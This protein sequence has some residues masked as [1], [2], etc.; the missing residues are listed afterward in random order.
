MSEPAARPSDPYAN[1]STAASL[2]YTD[3]DA[4][5]AQAEAER[6][7]IQ[8][9]VGTWE[10]I[11]SPTPPLVAS[12]EEE[13][14]EDVKPETGQKR[15]AGAVPDDDDDVRRFRLKR[16]TIGAGLGEIYDPAG[17]EGGGKEENASGAILSEGVSAGEVGAD[18]VAPAGASQRPKW[19]AR[20]W[21]RPRES[22]GG[23]A[24]SDEAAG[25][26]GQGDVKQE[27]EEAEPSLALQVRE[28]SLTALL[29]API[30]RESTEPVKSEEPG[31]PVKTEE[32][33][34]SSVKIEEPSPVPAMEAPPAG[35][36]L[37]RKRKLPAGGAARGRRT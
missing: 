36:S 3:P 31:G 5:C 35:G 23:G 10:V 22:G 26:G 25:E 37:F 1:Y 28:E 18:V 7:R 4:E 14:R 15:P 29:D 17:G 8:G 34:E 11:A 24:Q 20:G 33:A 6:R 2:G 13:Q 19:S 21:R 9:I 32:S 27:A 16:R 12:E 30:R